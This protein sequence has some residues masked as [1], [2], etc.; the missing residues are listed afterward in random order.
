MTLCAKYVKSAIMVR[1]VT[2]SPTLPSPPRGGQ[3]G[4]KEGGVA[5]TALPPRGGGVASGQVRGL[6]AGKKQGC[7]CALGDKGERCG[8][9][10]EKPEGKEG[11][12]QSARKAGACGS[13]D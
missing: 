11:V 7:R 9:L 12:Q 2:P 3:G 10:G 13:P 4:D 5:P 8:C 6:R 1:K